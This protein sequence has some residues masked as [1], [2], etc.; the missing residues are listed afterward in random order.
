MKFSTVSHIHDGSVPNTGEKE[1]RLCSVYHAVT[2]N[3]GLE[4][5]TSFRILRLLGRGGQGIVFLSQR[6]GSD[7][8]TLPVSLKFF[9]PESYRDDETYR[10]DM[11]NIA[12]VARQVAL[13][14]HDNLLDIH[15]FIEQDG[16][17]IME[18]EWVD[19]YDLH[20]LLTPSCL[21]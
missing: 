17:R 5:H 11:K 13:I 8:F 15:N 3:D 6:E 2:H 20:R 1:R 14:Q 18:M 19:G 7:H 12:R 4:W 9:S 16:I 21:E 10:E